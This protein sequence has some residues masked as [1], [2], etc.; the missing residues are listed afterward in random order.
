MLAIM[1]KVGDRLKRAREAAGLTQQ[2]LAEKIGATRSAIAQV[3]GGMTNSLNAENLAKAAKELG[4]AA[5]WLANGEGP[6][7]GLDAMGDALMHMSEEDRQQVFDFV[8]YKIE[9]APVPYT[10]Q[11]K[12]QSYAAMIERLKKDMSERKEN[13]KS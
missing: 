13:G 9:R 7:Q 1:D 10:A 12:A 2:Q 6:E 3:E 5:V 4:K 8:L 11:E